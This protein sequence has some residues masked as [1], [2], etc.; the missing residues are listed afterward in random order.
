MTQ[1]FSLRRASSSVDSFSL[2][3]LSCLPRITKL[4]CAVGRCR[5]S[6]KSSVGASNGGKLCK[7][8]ERKLYKAVEGMMWDWYVVQS[9]VGIEADEM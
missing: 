2:H 8:H 4:P 5:H 7:K 9:K 1:P 3:S 6:V